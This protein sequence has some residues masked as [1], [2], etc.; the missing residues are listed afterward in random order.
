[1]I[2]ENKFKEILKNINN[3]LNERN[4][5]YGD[6]NLLKFG[7]YGIMLRMDDKFERILN[8]IN[9]K[10]EEL[11]YEDVDINPYLEDALYDIAGYAIN[12]LRLLKGKRL[13]KYG[14]RKNIKER[15]GENN[16]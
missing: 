5:E 15:E 2:I 16:I 12:A 7:L 6:N 13:T 3:I 11:N 10:N 9:N 1:M 8:I 4:K 14:N